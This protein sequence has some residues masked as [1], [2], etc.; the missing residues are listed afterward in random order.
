MMN[1]Y[2]AS[3]YTGYGENTLGLYGNTYAYAQASGPTT[4]SAWGN[5]S[6]N[7]HLGD[8]DDFVSLGDN[9]FSFVST[10]GGDDVVRAFG[11]S[12]V[13]AFL[14]YGND[15]FQGGDGN[16]F[17]DGGSGNDI[18]SGRGGDDVLF[19]GNGNDALFGDAG[20][21]FLFGGAGE[22]LLVFHAHDFVAGGSGRDVFTF[23]ETDSM[24]GFATIA[25]FNPWEG[26]TLNLAHAGIGR[27]DLYN[28]PD[29]TLIA[30][31]AHLGV[32]QI[33]SGVYVNAS[34][35]SIV[36]VDQGWMLG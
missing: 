3:V 35:P 13:N 26:D 31:S 6:L 12:S 33:F 9:A 2:H 16:D 25:D 1:N 21:N 30:H 24:L 5:Y 23:E 28:M 11:Q 19:G 27:S 4:L 10:G 20:S 34:D 18:L 22:D 14:G 32:D 17:A 7:A 8:G 29:G 15:V 36:T